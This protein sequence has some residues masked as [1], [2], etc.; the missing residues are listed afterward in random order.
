MCIER[1]DVATV[2][3]WRGI[4]LFIASYWFWFLLVVFIVL[5]LAFVIFRAGP[6]AFIAIATPVARSGS[7]KQQI[8]HR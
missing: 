2:T 6:G 4:Q 8:L 7:P 3:V 1:Q 5:L